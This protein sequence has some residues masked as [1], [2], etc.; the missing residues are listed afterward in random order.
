MFIPFS[1]AASPCLVNRWIFPSILCLTDVRFASWTCWSISFLRIQSVAQVSSKCRSHGTTLWAA[2]LIKLR[3]AVDNSLQ[4]FRKTPS[5]SAASHTRIGLTFQISH[6]PLQL[7][8]MHAS[9]PRW[10]SCAQLSRVSKFVTPCLLLIGTCLG[11][12][13]G[14]VV[15]VPFDKV[16][17]RGEVEETTKENNVEAICKD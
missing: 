6:S 12:T 15:G 1:N 5:S 9:W 10:Y 8:S 7:R 3:R 14:G 2:W 11:P 16:T 4:V 13:V 17:S